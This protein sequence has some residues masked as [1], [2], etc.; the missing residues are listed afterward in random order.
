MSITAN[1]P[2]LLSLCILCIGLGVLI[3]MFIGCKI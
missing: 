1:V 3:G 2:Q